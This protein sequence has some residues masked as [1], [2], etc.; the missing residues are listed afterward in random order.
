MLHDELL[1]G[2]LAQVALEAAVEALDQQGPAD[3]RDGGV[4]AALAQLVADEGVLGAGDLIEGKLDAGV[5]QRLADQVAPCGGHVRVGLAEDH[6]QLALD[7]A[8]AREAVVA[9]APAQRV[10]VQV[11]RKVAHGGAHAWVQGAPER[12]VPAQA[13]ARRAHAPVARPRPQQQRHGQS[14]VLVVRGQFLG[15]LPPV[16]RVRAGFVVRQRLRPRE[17][18]ERRRRRHNV[19]VPGD[20]PREPSD[21]AGDCWGGLFLFII[22]TN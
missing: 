3:A 10:R 7:V 13:H 2:G 16:A 1:A 19:P 12:Q 17:L 20:L 6:G 5:V 21:R 4:V 8:G 18:V 9:L 22:W 15:H 11:G 14:G